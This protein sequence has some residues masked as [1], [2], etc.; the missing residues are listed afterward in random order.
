MF[1]W[2]YSKVCLSIYHYP[3]INQSIHRLWNT[4]N[5]VSPL[6]QTIGHHN[7]FTYS[8]D[9]SLHEKGLVSTCTRYHSNTYIHFWQ[10]K[11]CTIISYYDNWNS[12]KI[13]S[14][15]SMT[16]T[17]L[18]NMFTCVCLLITFHITTSFVTDIYVISSKLLSWGLS[19]DM[20]M[21][22]MMSLNYIHRRYLLEAY[23]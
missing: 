6:Y 16:T 1:I 9:F 22:S 20:M 8:V 4:D 10:I 17:I 5:P 2:F 14:K 3:F 11:T 23:H 13:M 18:I 12:I 19:Y 21:T 15:F 7:E